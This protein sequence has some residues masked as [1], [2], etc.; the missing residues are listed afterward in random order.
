MGKI[1]KRKQG[2]VQEAEFEDGRVAFVRI[3]GLQIH[4][5]EIGLFNAELRKIC[6]KALNL[7]DDIEAIL[8][9]SRTLEEAARHLGNLYLPGQRRT[10][11]EKDVAE[12]EE[13][14]NA[15]THYTLQRA[16]LKKWDYFQQITQKLYVEQGKTLLD[17]NHAKTAIL[18]VLEAYMDPGHPDHAKVV[19]YLTKLPFHEPLR[20]PEDG[21]WILR[22]MNIKA[23]A[24]LQSPGEMLREF[25]AA[26]RGLKLTLGSR[27]YDPVPYLN[28]IDGAQDW[29]DA[30]EKSM[31][32]RSWDAAIGFCSKAIDAAPNY[33]ESYYK[34][35]ECYILKDDF[36]SAAGAL[37]SVRLMPMAEKIFKHR[38]DYYAVYLMVCSK[39]PDKTEA[40]AHREKLKLLAEKYGVS[41]PGL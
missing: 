13:L 28:D 37:D 18:E 2:R 8:E 35:A 23:A 16:P 27:Y 3:E 20:D 29:L 38:P 26:V 24:F 4:I 15:M 40:A 12:H 5:S 6:T 22:D 34:A 36:Q 14:S 39:M 32:R 17:P 33:L 10:V 25:R 9:T 41:V 21:L 7:Y 19:E 1:T 31:Q 11:H 30:A